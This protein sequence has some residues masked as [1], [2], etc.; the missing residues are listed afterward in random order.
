M[1]KITKTKTALLLSRCS[2]TELHGKL[3]SASWAHG[4]MLF[5]IVIADCSG[6]GGRAMRTVDL[7][8]VPKLHFRF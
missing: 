7:D 3:G 1:I 6:K 2:K 5:I 4:K 8:A